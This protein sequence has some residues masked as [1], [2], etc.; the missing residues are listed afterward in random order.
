VAKFFLFLLFTISFIWAIKPQQAID[1]VLGITPGMAV[2]L[3]EEAERVFARELDFDDYS[4]I[5]TDFLARGVINEISPRRIIGASRALFE[6][7]MAGAPAEI[8]FD[9]AEIGFN[10]PLTSEQIVSSCKAKIHGNTFGIQPVIVEELLYDCIENGYDVRVIEAS[11]LGVEKAVRN[12]LSQSR[13][14]VA[15]MVRFAQGV[16]QKTMKEIIDEEIDYLKKNRTEEQLQNDRFAEQIMANGVD[17]S[18][19]REVCA[20]AIEDNWNNS[21]L[22]EVFRGLDNVRERGLPVEKAMIAFVVNISQG[23]DG[24]CSTMVQREIAMLA[25]DISLRKEATIQPNEKHEIKNHTQTSKKA[26]TVT[27]INEQSFEHSIQLFLTANAPRKP[28]STPYKWGGTTRNGVDC[29]GFTYVCYAEQNIRIPRVSR[30]Q[31]REFKN[32]RLLVDKNE[33]HYGDLVFFSSNGHGRIT[34]VGIF[35]KKNKKGENLFV[36]S[37][38]TPGVNICNLDKNRY[39]A[40][41]YVG[42]VRVVD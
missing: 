39:W 15:L 37:S 8:A 32:K 13:M 22:T 23:Y 20:I 40:P 30:M 21:E 17:G 12:Q 34:H 28:S 36:H 27:G 16:E 4:D 38:C 35:Y 7:L 18:L 25:Q 31:Y 10:I 41:R 33:L 3:K 6:A 26:I 14:A 5:M 2:E 1:N 19:V 11:V 42:A 29:S 9:I 24:A